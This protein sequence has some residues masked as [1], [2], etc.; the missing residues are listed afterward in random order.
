MKDQVKL[1]IKP[2]DIS[3]YYNE[4]LNSI[5]SELKDLNDVLNYTDSVPIIKKFCNI[6]FSKRDSVNYIDNDLL[7]DDY[8]LG[9]GDEIIFC[10]GSSTTI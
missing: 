5:K 9:F 2:G 7:T 8:I 6:I 3:K 10:L 1:L 4:K